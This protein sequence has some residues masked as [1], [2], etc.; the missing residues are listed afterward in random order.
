VLKAG[1]AY[2][3]VDLSYP[4]E[5]ISFMFQDV[6]PVL[7]LTRSDAAG[8]LPVDGNVVTLDDPDTA[9]VIDALPGRDVTDDDRTCPL[10]P[11]HPAFAIYTSGSTGRPKGVVVEHHSLNYYLAWA[12]HVYPGVRGRAL[13]HSSVSFDLTV[14]G[15]YAPLTAGGCVHLIELD[16]NTGAAGRSWARPTF[17]KAT[18]SHLP[19][20]TSLPPRFSP[21]KELV[22]GGE[23]LLGEVLDEWRAKYPGVTVYNEYGP[24]ETTVECMDCH[25]LPGEKI[26]PGVVTLGVPSWNTQMYVLDGN[27]GPVPVGVPGEVYIAGDLVTRCYH[28]RPGLTSS[29]Y[30]ANPFGPP[31]SRMYRSGDVVKRSANGNLEFL[32][33]V[34][35]Q[36]KVRGYRIE[37]GEI[38]AVLNQHLE[39][40]HARVI[41]REDRPGDKRL[42]AYYVPATADRPDSQA[43][44]D[45][46]AEYL[47]DYMV[48]AAFV[49]ME[50]L[51]LTPNRK[52]DRRNLPAP[53]Y[54]TELDGAEPGSAQEEILC[55]LFAEALG[56][57]KVGVHDN[58]FA[59]GGHSLLAVRLVSRIRSTFGV[60]LPLRVLFEATT[61]AAVAAQLSSAGEARPALRRVPRPQEVL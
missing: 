4:A 58:F 37:L 17:V 25:V 22:L 38:E 48:P 14:T 60:E 47:P 36:V 26:P 27:L 42:V 57:P 55:R 15:I 53:V 32:A 13:V 5:R 33:R 34:D 50:A 2:V 39:V 43:L 20:L 19:L 56:V 49:A 40:A 18:P 59:L 6:D 21:T 8:R 24:T 51:P 46:C 11:H 12:R 30:V 10:R 9:R 35:D 28:R 16:E 1:A 52:L 41:V 7:V 23:P 44:R 45:T 61:V 54:Q 3:A 29:R 31:G